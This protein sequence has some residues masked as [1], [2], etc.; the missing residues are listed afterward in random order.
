[1]LLLLASTSEMLLNS[2]KEL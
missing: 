1:M 2:E